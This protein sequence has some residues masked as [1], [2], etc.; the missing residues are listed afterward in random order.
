MKK[1]N[2]VFSRFDFTMVL[3][4]RKI[5]TAVENNLYRIG[6]EINMQC[7]IKKQRSAASPVVEIVESRVVN[8]NGMP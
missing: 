3:S 2:S 5:K 4:S 1:Q 7:L 8:R 6:F